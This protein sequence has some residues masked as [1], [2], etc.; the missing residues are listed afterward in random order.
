MAPRVF[1][2]VMRELVMYWRRGGNS[3][4]PYLDDSSFFKE[5]L[6]CVVLCLRVREYFQ[7]AG[8][9]INVPEFQLDRC[10]AYCNWDLT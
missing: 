5:K 7:Q 2:K 3:V 1:S 8:L 9:I 4:L 10:C 6:A